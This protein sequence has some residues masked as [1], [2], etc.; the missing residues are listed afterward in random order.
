[1]VGVVGGGGGGGQGR[2]RT[3]QVL[4]GSEFI[5]QGAQCRQGLFVCWLVA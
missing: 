3:Q 5:E 1:M 4:E 2:R